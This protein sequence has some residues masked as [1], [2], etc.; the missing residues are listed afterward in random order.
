MTPNVLARYIDHTCLVPL[1][2]SRDI[3]TLC[4]EALEWQFASVCVPPAFVEE[5]FALLDPSSVH[6]GTVIGFPFGYTAPSIKVREA[7]TAQDQGADEIDIVMQVGRFKGGERKTVEEELKSV[8]RATPGIIH[9]IIIESD[10]LTNDEKKDAVRMVLGVG[11]D[12]VKTSSGYGA[13][14]ATEA[15][16]RL[17]VRTAE[18]RIGVKA[19][20]GIR[21]AASA[22]AMIRA[23]ATRIGTSSAIT[24]LSELKETPR[25]GKGG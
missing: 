8:L 13:G 17:I 20:G 23:G 25:S 2:T 19:S 12:F 21:S 14:G 5:A 11:A 18:G 7:V 4:R 15:D 9:K 24:I 10:A 22:L 1:V 6:V 3:E 16:V